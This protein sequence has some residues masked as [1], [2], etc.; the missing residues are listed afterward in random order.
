M[1]AFSRTFMLPDNLGDDAVSASFEGGVLRVRVR[2]PREATPRR[3]PIT[4]APGTSQGPAST[5]GGEA[6]G[7]STAG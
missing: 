1:S 4:G 3:I 6:G 2:R 5:G 7:V